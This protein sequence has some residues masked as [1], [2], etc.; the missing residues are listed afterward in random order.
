MCGMPMIPVN[1]G[2]AKQADEFIT[3]FFKNG[4]LGKVYPKLIYPIFAIGILFSSFLLFFSIRGKSL[5]IYLISIILV[6]S[7]YGFKNQ[8][9]GVNYG[10]T[11]NYKSLFT[12][13]SGI[14]LLGPLLFF[15]VKS[16][17][18]PSFKWR[19]RYWLHFVPALLMFLFYA[20]LLVMPGR[21]QTRFMSSPFEVLFS[22]T[23]QIITVAGGFLYLVSA[24]L[25]YKKWKAQRGSQHTWLTAWLKRFMTGMSVL[26]LFWGTIIIINFWLYNFGIATI[27]YNPLWICFGGVL[28]WLSIEV[29]LNPTFFLIKKRTKYANGNGAMTNEQLLQHKADLETLMNNQKLYTDPNLSLNKLAQIMGLNPRSLSM[30]LNTRIGKNFYDFINYYRIEEVKQL[31]KDPGNRK[32]TIEAIANKSGFKSKSSFNSAFRKYVHMTPREYINSSGND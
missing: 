19:S 14:L 3:P 1:D 31:L 8:L 29:L 17:L 11:S 28:L 10:L 7:L 13:I 22:H 4:M 26:L 2:F 12:P 27:T 5:N 30:I 16:L 23:E 15:H 9:Y 21:V 25:L 6:L 32:L 24:L 18:F 20:V